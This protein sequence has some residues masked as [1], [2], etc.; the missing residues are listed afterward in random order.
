MPADHFGP[1]FKDTPLYRQPQWPVNPYSLASALV[2]AAEGAL[3][4]FVTQIRDRSSRSGGIKVS[5]LQSIQLRI[6]ESAAEID[7]ARRIILGN[8]E[9][10]HDILLEQD[11]LPTEIRARNKRDMAFTSVL[12]KRAIERIFYASGALSILLTEDIQR[13]YRDVNAGAQQVI[14]NWDSQ[15][16][17]FGRVKLG[18][19]PGK[20][21]W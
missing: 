17:V 15:A 16:T 6:A 13:Y 4:S 3:D 5:E 20:F 7:A 2:G 10:T 21:F 11:E 8:L 19:D 14:L 12:A 1:K 18:L 9:E